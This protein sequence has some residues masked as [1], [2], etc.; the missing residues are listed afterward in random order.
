M[1][2]KD[3]AAPGRSPPAFVEQT[4]GDRLIA[5]RY[6]IQRLLKKAL[7]VETLLA[8]DLAQG[9]SVVVKTAPADDL[10]PATVMRL[11][12]E[13][14]VLAR[15]SSPWFVPLREVGR[16]DGFFYLVMP[17]VPGAT[18]QARL[19]RGPLSLQDA[20]TV[21][22]CLMAALRELHG[23]GVLHR[24]V[25][26]ANVIVD[27]G[28][29]LDRAVLID[30]GLARSSRLDA[31][32]RDQPV[33]TARY[34]SP[35]GAGLLEH[36]V[37]ECS[38]L[39]SAGVVLFEC[40]A[41]RTPFKGDS[42][43]EVLRQH[44]ALQPPELRSLGLAVPRA[45]DEIIQRLLRKDPRDRY[46]SA[47]AVLADLDEL[48]EATARGV[49]DPDLVVGLHD[50]RGSL[51][52][53]A[54]VGRGRD[55]DVLDAQ[56]E[57]ARLGKT[58]L[59]LLEAESGGGK[60]R[61]L[62]EMAQRCARR[63][64]WVLRGQGLDQ[65]TQRPF[66]VLAGVVAELV[67]A[68]RTDHGLR[69][70]IRNG[71]GDQRAAAC[72][73][74]PELAEILGEQQADAL[75]PESF[76]ETR[77]LQAL[78]ALLDVLGARDRPVLVLLDD[79]QW[80][81]QLALKLLD[82]WRRR[83]EEEKGTARHVLV[84]V[85]FRSE[86]TPSD[87]LLRRI[88]H[89]AHVVLS[90]FQTSD[91]RRLAESMAGP[92]PEEVLSVVERLGEGSPFM[93]SAALRGLVESGAL[94]ADPAGWRIEP[95]ALADIQSSRHAAA[96][97]ARRLELLPAT[98]LRLLS[99][100]AV[101][102]RE[103]DLDVAAA[104]AGQSSS[105]AISS[106]DEARRRHI[107]WVKPQ[108]NRCVF[109]HDK[110]RQT[111]LSRLAPAERKE[112]HRKAALHLEQVDPPPVF[113]LAYHF[114]AAGEFGRAFPYALG[115][116]EMARGQHSLESAEQQYRIAARGTEQ[117]DAVA[118]QRVA[119]GLGDV[120]MLRG[121]YQEAGEQLEIAR[122]RALDD[123]TRAETEGKLGEL[124]FK[125]GDARA[126]MESIERALGL[127][128][129]KV[130]RRKATFAVMLFWEALVQTLH[131]WLPMLFLNRRTLDGAA[132]DLMILR[133][134]SRLSYAY[135]FERGSLP[136]LW[137]HLREMNRA[138]RYP[139]TPEMA[140]VYS[141]HAAAM[142]LIPPLLQRGIKYARQ[143][144]A[145][146]KGF[147]DLWG[148]G[149]S[150]NFYGAVLFA[151]SQF[152]ECI[153]K[154]REAVRLLERTGDQWELNIARFYIAACLYRLGDLGPAVAEAQRIHQSG[155]QLGA[156]QA[157]GISLEI[158]A[159][160]SG[161]RLALDRIEAALEPL[162]HDAQGIAQVL[163]A[164]GIYFLGQDRPAEAAEVFEQ[165]QRG[166]RKA[167]IHNV[168]TS[169]I[170]SW[171]ATA[172]R[173]EAEKQT[174][175]T[176]GK[177]QVILRRARAAARG[178][179][180]NARSFKNDLPHALRE[181]GLAAAMQGRTNRARIYLNHSLA[182]AE[183]QEAR[184][185]HA[186][187]LLA[188][189][190]V[191]LELDWPGAEADV[192]AAQQALRALG[193]DF[194]LDGAVAEVAILK[195]ATLSL[196]DRFDTVLDA[197]RRIASALSR[198]EIFSAVRE[199]ALRLLRG[200][201]CFLL[202]LRN[203]NAS[204]DLTLAS[205][206][207]EGEHSRLMAEQA[208]AA[209]R[210]LVFAEERPGEAGET[211]MLAGVRSALCAPI[212]VRGSPAG[213]FYVEH[214][215][216]AG[217]FGEDE[218]RLAEFIAT[219]A[220]A[221]LENAEGFAELRRLNETLEER[222]AERTAAAEARARELAVSNNELQ[223]T[224]AELKRSEDELRVA[225]EAAERANR[226]KSD[227]LANMS[228]EIRTPMNG[229]IGMTEL[230]LQTELTSTQRD[231]LTI[232]MQSADSLLR[233]LNDI[234]DFSK[235]E[236]GKLEL[237]SM[238]FDLRDRLGDTVHALGFR[239]SQKGLELVYHF[240]PDVPDQVIGD[241]GRLS[242]IVINLVGNAIK[243]T[244]IGEVA[245]GVALDA[246]TDDEVVLHFTI[247]DTGPGIPVDKQRLIFEAFSQADASTTR[248]YGG[249]GLGL[250]ISTQLTSL[251]GGRIWVESQVGKGS[252]FHF[253]ARLL[254][255]PDAAG[256][257]PLAPDEL[258]EFAVLIVDDNAVNR[259]MFLD[260]LTQWGMHPVAV[261]SG[262][263]AL[264]EME[265][266]ASAGRP[267]RLVLLDAMM[268]DMD[269]FTLAGR[270][271]QDPR[272]SECA[273]IMLSSAGQTEHPAP[274]AELGI[275]RRLLKP[276]RQSDLREA[277][278]RTLGAGPDGLAPAVETRAGADEF[279]SL[280]ILLAE[281]GLVNQQVARG[282]L[283]A[284][285]HRV[286]VAG[287]GN[288]AVAALERERFDLVLMDVQ[289][290]E[291]DGFEA[292]DQIRR[293]EAATGGHVPIIAMTAHA[294]KGDRE[295]CLASG[296]DGYLSKPVQARTL[297]DA[298]E[299][300]G[301]TGDAPHA[302]PE[303]QPPATDLLDWDGAVARVGGRTEL[304]KRLVRL[305]FKESDRL[306]PEIRQAI[307]R[308][309]AASLRRV[310]H[311]L[312]GSLDCFGAKSAV[313]A[314][315]QLEIMGRNGILPTAN[316]VFAQLERDVERLK[317][318]LAARAEE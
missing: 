107:V 37:N 294:L 300:T 131:T 251:M 204:E 318:A 134:Y 290:P 271:R 175:L 55:L 187:T 149:Q 135:W 114:D 100:G 48:A 285:G 10:S 14:G 235:I 306:I 34:L 137:A 28:A 68:A 93:V 284:R 164:K 88:R 13:A 8:T 232:V 185:E 127:L 126:G 43:G 23:H 261:E 272:L 244:E 86:E 246:R 49:A 17:F 6:R 98:A 123:V 190:R 4:N 224:A 297:Y 287:N 210:V 183:R 233:L 249:T 84:V 50:R 316:E 115:A 22:R 239:A 7:D 293:R 206:E 317:P 229:V 67:A 65:A 161:G 12:H 94:V 58:G 1:T 150:L 103:F 70:R 39:Y 218:Q 194:I 31:S 291:M 24:D 80:A 124:A 263:A 130:P 304:L 242:Q 38:D 186:Q 257:A 313:A 203:T 200:E 212:F 108:D 303:P 76:A 296:M 153:E 189:G 178:G 154:C 215:H 310:A 196:A 314:A 59:V 148:Q 52:E 279:R 105:E 240:A 173:R 270:I 277:I 269:G 53:P 276:I 167:G 228:H 258:R 51:T 62:L 174:N 169:P 111:L 182:V 95:M 265:R 299:G 15:I 19:S 214:R 118:C 209:G 75:G 81:D 205:G 101:L 132:K 77:S 117:A 180:G 32:L 74:A 145:L 141:A 83:Q 162:S 113:E 106:L 35:E 157:A 144:Y 60:T 155:L 262:P 253:T 21:G 312:K 268:P 252:T 166:A 274:L 222:V 42:V 18:L 146:R 3:G 63:G 198:T 156:A 264:A 193:A 36:D 192:T 278:L 56:M 231:Y 120:L 275:A 216:V 170:L 267:F 199:A 89:S 41:G 142:T 163:Q 302:V 197:G 280:R 309:D 128:G 46:Q 72:A 217:L 188:R 85:A 241:Q 61:L 160:A 181:C 208:V 136:T 104:L 69:E 255:Q 289:M 138:E 250:T 11:E 223:R 125:Q 112:L 311:A 201:R 102:G 109:I 96:F 195:P 260:V 91:I 5:G 159:K 298:V 71:L 73:A 171:L 44:L 2:T 283:E 307:A 227:F 152:K 129:E 25:K 97:L 172:L 20:L 230:T 139:P 9:D 158:W 54:F 99:I 221:A 259:R 266:A 292:T 27:E 147:G 26:P 243:F 165:A 288:E 143:S 226:A 30:L 248:R 256:T 29:P 45:L 245:V 116:A 191:G 315:L 184:L 234:L 220:G 66:Q 254:V 122:A 281:D 78:A 47:E 219:I 308:G 110:L 16:H 151:G 168:W 238:P 133:L 57:Q 140:Q 79:C 282:L 207:I 177:R 82:L 286:V 305:F 237:E 119:A 273:M 211:A 33:G 90:P 301:P 121:R 247:A 213:C 179:L 176:P 87:H 92:L 64:G 40:L 202:Q 295:R 225:K 236:A